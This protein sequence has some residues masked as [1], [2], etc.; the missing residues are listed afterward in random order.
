MNLKRY[1]TVAILAVAGIGC[2]DAEPT[3]PTASPPIT[4]LFI[5]ARNSWTAE[6]VTLALIRTADGSTVTLFRDA[7]VDGRPRT[8]LDSIGPFQEDP[9]IVRELL[10]S[11]DV[12]ALNAPN[13]PGA[14]CRTVNGHRTCNITSYDYS[15]VMLVESG[16]QVRVQR[17]TGLERSTGNP[18]ARALGDFVLAW[19]RRSE[20]AAASMTPLDFQPARRTADGG[21]HSRPP[22]E[23]GSR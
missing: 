17:Y 4:R 13:A 2:R 21:R 20:G 1:F 6:D 7:T 9:P 3:S 23:R 12:W 10:T 15:V 14:A 19:A 22:A 11:F 18:S 16:G 8:V 5:F